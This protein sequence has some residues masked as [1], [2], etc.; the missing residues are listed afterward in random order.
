MNFLC[1]LL[2][3]LTVIGYR[4]KSE[5]RAKW[6]QSLIKLLKIFNTD[7]F[8]STEP[9]IEQIMVDSERGPVPYLYKSG[10]MPTF[11]TVNMRSGRKRVATKEASM[12]YFS[13]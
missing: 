9:I 12:Y 3:R 5:D 7:I 2:S 13:L 4:P 11:K 10:P 6:T 8:V 1:S